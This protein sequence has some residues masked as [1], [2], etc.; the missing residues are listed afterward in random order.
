MVF[1]PPATFNANR[2]VLLSP[3]NMA[4]L[5]SHLPLVSQQH[6]WFLSYSTQ[7][8]G[9]LLSTMYLRWEDIT[10][11]FERKNSNVPSILVVYTST[12]KV[13]GGYASDYWR[14]HGS[15]F[16]G[17]PD[18]FVFSFSPDL[19]VHRATRRNR[20]Y[21]L[22][23]EDCIAMGGSPNAAIWIDKSLR[24]GTSGV[25]DTFGS[26]CLSDDSKDLGSFH[27]LALEVWALL[28]DASSFEFSKECG[29]STLSGKTF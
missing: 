25:C 24:R 9:T 16:F 1:E 27:I 15:S 17:R 6:Q 29:F 8:H 3:D 21:Q 28:R 13:F 14:V 10:Y 5:R 23:K 19:M 12:G 26:P 7:E 20:N 4:E 11:Q 22:A 2:P 18:C